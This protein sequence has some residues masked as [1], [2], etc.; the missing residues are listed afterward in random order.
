MQPSLCRSVLVLPLYPGHRTPLR[1]RRRLMRRT[2]HCLSDAVRRVV[3][4]PS[5]VPAFPYTPPPL[6]LLF[7]SPPNPSSNFRPGAC[8]PLYFLPAA[9]AACWFFDL[10]PHYVSLPADPIPSRKAS[11]VPHLPLPLRSRT[12]FTPPCGRPVAIF[13]PVL[14]ACVISLS[15]VPLTHLPYAPPP[16]PFLQPAIIPLRVFLRLAD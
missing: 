16:A 13:S 6:P 11:Y 15:I 3:L 8:S 12:R 2:P 10:F 4:L 5:L 7:R 14:P 1:T 9:T